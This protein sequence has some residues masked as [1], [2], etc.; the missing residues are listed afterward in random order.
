MASILIIDDEVTLAKNT[1][2][3]LE[4]SNHDVITAATAMEG[5]KLFTEN[6]PDIIVLDYKLP[7]KDGLAVIADI[8]ELDA[9]VPII[10]VTGHGSITLAVNAMKAGANDL[11]TKPIALS[12]LRDRI[13]QLSKRQHNESRLKYYDERER[14]FGSLDAIIGKSK[15]ILDLKKRISKVAG[16]D[17]GESLPPIL[18]TGETGTGKELIARSC[19]YCSN[20]RD[21][22]FIEVNCA[23]I[24]HNLLESELLG[25]ERGAFTDAK[26]RKIGLF[27]AADEGTIFLDEIGEMSISLQA[28]LLKVIEDGRFRRLGSVQER[29]INIQIIT[30][31]N[32]DLEKLISEGLFRS[33]L[34]FRLKVLRLITPPLRERNG[35]ALLLARHFLSDFSRRY[36]K[37]NL[38]FSPDAERSIVHHQW[39]GNVREL[40]NVVEQ[41]VLLTDGP[42]IE[43]SDLLLHSANQNQANGSLTIKELIN[44]EEPDG[45]SLD[46]V[47]KEL[48]NN[49]LHEAKGNVSKAAKILGISRDTL[50]YRIGKHDIKI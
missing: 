9:N 6:L 20:R 23:T 38:T 33:D 8:R 24:P 25:Y 44:A 29:Q 42:S 21:K 2:R 16:I 36:R 19:H 4:K 10:M 50:R 41:A 3:F 47:E 34:Y 32:Q 46:R 13:S 49:A 26:E 48:L 12:D 22:P 28:K 37:S 1:A 17:T 7:D 31:T 39:P 40:R 43:P 30:A 14:N 11:M 45:S 18:I 15:E 27:E 5:V 35:D